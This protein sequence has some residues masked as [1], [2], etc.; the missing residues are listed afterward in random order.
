MI[1][2]DALDADG[3]SQSGKRIPLVTGGTWRF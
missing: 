1:G 2:T 3:I